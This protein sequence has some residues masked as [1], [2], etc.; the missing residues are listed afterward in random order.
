MRKSTILI[1]ATAVMFLCAVPTVQAQLSKEEQKCQSTAAKK[2]RV[3]FKKRLKALGSCRDLV[4]RGKLPTT[5]DCELETKTADK[6]AKAEQKFRD[7]LAL[8]CTDT[9]VAGLA[10]GGQ[11]G[12]VTTVAALQDCQVEEHETETDQVLAVIYDPR[13]EGTCDGGLQNNNP[14]NETAD[15]T[16]G[17]CVY[18][19]EQRDCTKQMTKILGKLGSKRQ[20]ILQKCKKSVA[21]GSLP[22]GTDCEA[23]TQADLDAA[24]QAARDA[25]T[26]VCT[27]TAAA[28]IQFGGA[29]DKITDVDSVIACSTC[30]TNRAA[31]E[32]ILVQ[33]GTPAR[34]GAAELKQITNMSE[35]VGGRMS[36]CRVN[37]YLL[38]NDQ[39]RVVIQDLQRNLFGIGQYGGQIIDADLVRSSGPDRDNFEEWAIS[40]NIESTAHYTSLT[41]VNDG[42]DGGPAIL[43]ATGIDDLLDFVNPSSIIA[44]FGFNLPPSVDDVNLPVTVTTDYILEPGTNYVR[45]ETSVQNTSAAPLDIFFGEYIGGSGEIEMFQP[46]YGFGEPLVTT[47][48]SGNAPVFCN[49]TAFSGEGDADGVSYGYMN[50]IRGS[51]T[52]TTSGVHV[53]QLKVEV[54]LALVGIAGP[55]FHIG[56]VGDPDDTLEVTRYFIVGDG[57]VSSIADTRNEIQCLPTGTLSGAVTAGGNPAVR[58]DVAITTSTLNGPAGLSK[59]IFLHTRTDDDG[60]YSVTLP[61]GSYNVSANLDGHPFEGGGTTPVD[62]PIVMTAFGTLT[63]NIALPAAGA[64][65]VTVTDEDSAPIAAKVS[66]VGFDK[67]PNPIA[68]QSI[69]GL[70]NNRTAQFGDAGED[71][72]PFGMANVTHAGIDGDSGVITLEPGNYQVYVS[73]GLEYSLDSAPV[74]ITA[75]ATTPLAAT[76]ERV[77]DSTG[78]ISGDFHVHSMDSPDAQVP[79]DDRVR[80]MLAEGL[81]FFATTDHDFRADYQPVIDALGATALIGTTPGQETTTFDYGHFNVWPAVIDPTKVN[82]GSIDHGGAAPDGQDYPSAGYYSSSPAQIIADA[83]AAAPGSSNTVQIN[84]IHSHFGVDGGSG[85]GIDTALEPPAS[86]VPPLARRLN[87]GITNLFSDTFD[88]LEIWIGDDRAQIVTNFLGQNAGDWF[89]LI[90]QGIVRSGIADSDTHTRYGNGGSY[91]RTM[92]AMPTDDPGDL[93][94]AA[95]TI[96]DNLNAGRAFGTNG[97]MVRVSISADSTSQT[98]SLELGDPLIISTVDGEVDIDVEIQSPTWAEFD[99]V[100]YYIN[101]VTTRV[102]EEDVQTGAGLIDVNRYTITPTTVQNV[103]PV[104]VPVA[105]TSSSRLEASTTLTLTGLTEDIWVVV[106]VKGTD[107]VSRPLYPV[108]PLSLKTS[109]NTTLANLTDGNLGEDGIPALSFTNPLFVDVDGGGWT[110]PGVQVNP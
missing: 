24:F 11:C 99:T 59:N 8:S 26:E 23:T 93:S 101:P 40:L 71:P 46:A 30:S 45:V 42:S 21:R 73:H 80:G 106:M 5:T 76:V 43:R 32:L 22:E 27:P 58:A 4:A 65:Q 105:G 63:E 41:I 33:H 15:C 83:H 84:H 70:V 44:G 64:L 98:A 48:C 95:E 68:A 47:A 2:G 13:T 88:A 60:N 67:S 78:F 36:R 55:P 87:P 85:L 9:V 100:E 28:D 20:S 103:V 97:P 19:D 91:P 38:A 74:V 86:T 31:D 34:G 50:N 102:V 89:N 61:P 104:P 25:I 96:S 52:F 72:F 92:I 57:T 56:P 54:L 90:N 39:V 49:F 10:W 18:S 51:T 82:N 108:V 77:I 75:G 1:V 29:C 110:P 12:G 35:C 16:N 81:D 7:K 94:A 69:F 53:P 14:C 66:V 17:V 107:G 109:T 37:D 6:L 62:H 79:S 3:F